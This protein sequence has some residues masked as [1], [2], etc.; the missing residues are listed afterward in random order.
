MSD[1]KTYLYY[2]SYVFELEKRIKKCLL[3]KQEKGHRSMIL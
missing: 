3:K 2:S 1:K